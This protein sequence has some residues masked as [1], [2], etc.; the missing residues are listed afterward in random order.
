MEVE[1]AKAPSAQNLGKFIVS[2]QDQN[3]SN[4]HWWRYRWHPVPP[5]L[6]I[7]YIISEIESQEKI[8]RLRGKN[9]D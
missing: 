4:F 5:H 7:Y 1:G 3:K 9:V 2:L 8:A 6:R